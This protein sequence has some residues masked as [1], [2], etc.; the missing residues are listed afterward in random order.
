MNLNRVV[1]DTNV[2]ISALLNPNGTP[3]KVINLAVNQCVILQSQVTYQE[4]ETRLS[5]KKFDKYLSKK[6]GVT[7]LESLIK[8]SLF[9]EITHKTVICSDADDNKFLELAVSGIADYL[10]TGDNDLL[11]IKNYQD[12][13]IITPISFLNLVENN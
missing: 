8:K 12:I 7:F 2:F 4:L 6:D 3:R 13:P 10:I 1:I 11:K 9:I 5:K